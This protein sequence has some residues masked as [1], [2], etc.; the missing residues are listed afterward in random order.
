MI[1]SSK[2]V[3]FA[4]GDTVADVTLRLLD[5]YGYS[6]QYSGTTKDGFYLA[7]IGGFTLKG[8]EYDSFGEFDAGTGSGWMITLNEEF[9]KSGASDFKVEN[10]DVIKWQYTCQLGEDIGDSF[11]Q[12]G[13]DDLGFVANDEK[14]D[15]KEEIKEEIKEET[16]RRVFTEATFSDIC[17]NDWYYDAV[18]F[19]YENDLMQGT[20]IGFEPDNNMTRAMLVT[21][22][23]RLGKGEKTDAENTFVDVKSG[24]WYTDAVIWAKEN[25]IVKGVSEIEFAPNNNISREQIVTVIYRYAT[26]KGYDANELSELSDYIDSY[27]ISETALTAFK[28][29]VGSKLINGTSETTLS[30]KD[31]TTRAQVAAILQRFCSTEFD[32]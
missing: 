23:Y 11:Y 10:G 28:W 27:E 22:L 7:A 20:G 29:A 21:V 31:T 13:S 9:I 32:K 6:Y 1:I 12:D 4:E 8:I 2:S 17:S 16:E 14:E 26:L 30:P 18:K 3:P 5:A 25:G 19:V 24:E 15:A